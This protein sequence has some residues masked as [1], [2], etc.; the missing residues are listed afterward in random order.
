MVSISLQS[1]VIVHNTLIFSRMYMVRIFSSDILFFGDFHCC[2]GPCIHDR[3]TLAPVTVS[4]INR[5]ILFSASSYRALS[6]ATQSHCM[7]CT[8]CFNSEKLCIWSIWCVCVFLFTFTNRSD[9]I[10]VGFEMKI[11]FV[12]LYDVNW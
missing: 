12:P 7:H 10:P 5:T 1:E 6:V 9:D 11:Y 8:D 4:Q 2:I 3:L